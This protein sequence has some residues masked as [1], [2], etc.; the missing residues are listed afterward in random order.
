M[1]IVCTTF[2]LYLLSE[3]ILAAAKACLE[4]IEELYVGVVRGSVRRIR[5][6]YRKSHALPLLHLVR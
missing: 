4:E 5:E 2:V 3:F 6:V 1:F